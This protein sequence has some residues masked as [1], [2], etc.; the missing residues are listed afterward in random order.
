[1]PPF[2]R[3]PVVLQRADGHALVVNSLA[4]KRA[5]IDRN[6]PDPKGRPTASAA[7]FSKTPPVSPRACRSTMPWTSVERL[8]PP[9]TEVDQLC[10]LYAAG[11]I[12]LR[13][14][15]AIYGPSADADRLLS[16]GPG[17]GPSDWPAPMRGIRCWIREPT[18]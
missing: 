5:G 2:L 9:P 7:L 14:Y 13:L 3:R 4:L 6:T 17:S 12:Q 1:M 8:L 15:D 18:S 10:Q 16:E 11:R